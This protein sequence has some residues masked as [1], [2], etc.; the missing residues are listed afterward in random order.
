[1]QNNINKEIRHYQES[2]FMGM[3]LRQTICAVAAIVMAGLIYYFGSS[4]LGQETASWLCI[5]AAAPLAAFGFFTYDGMNFEQFLVA[6][7][8]SEVVC[9]GVRV[10]K[11]ENR[12]KSTRRAKQKRKGKNYETQ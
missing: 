3:N 6:V 5:V 8:R 11:A 1:M 2:V 4:I 10:W 9:A 12:V 7:V